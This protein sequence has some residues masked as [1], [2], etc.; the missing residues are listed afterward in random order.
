[1]PDTERGIIMRKSLLIGLIIAFALCFSALAISSNFLALNVVPGEKIAK[2]SSSGTTLVNGGWG[3]AISDFGRDDGGADGPTS[4]FIDNNG[5]IYILDQ[6]NQRIK[7]YSSSGVFQKA[8]GID[9]KTV[10]DIA[11]LPGGEI[12]LLDPILTKSLLKYSPNGKLSQQV[13]INGNFRYASSLQPQGNNIFVENEHTDMYKI[14]DDGQ[15]LTPDNQ[16]RHKVHGRINK[17]RHGT[18]LTAKRVDMRNFLINV[19]D[20]NGVEK[21]KIK[22]ESKMDILQLLLL[23]SDARGN[24]YA[25]MEIIE[26]GPAPDYDL[27]GAEIVVLKYDSSGKLLGKIDLPADNITVPYKNLDVDDNGNVY[28]LQTT[29]EGVKLVKWQFDN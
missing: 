9:R 2:P 7:V 10:E 14:V 25:G 28:Q 24:I 11:I 21:L 20:S 1:M 3:N 12:Y 5:R 6:K 26:A 15:V 13:K 16:V 19:V 18:F 23:A 27:L 22:T 29:E 17:G 8:I 4:F